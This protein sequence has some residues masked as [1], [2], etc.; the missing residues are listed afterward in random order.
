MRKRSDGEQGKV[1]TMVVVVLLLID[2]EFHLSVEFQWFLIA[3]SV[4]P[5]R[6][7][8]MVAHLLPYIAWAWTMRLSSSFDSWLHLRVGKISWT[9][10]KSLCLS[11]TSFERERERVCYWKERALNRVKERERLKKT[12]STLWLKKMRSSYKIIITYALY[13]RKQ[14]L[15]KANSFSLQK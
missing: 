2:E 9:D 13:T 3:L 10:R 15:I 12:E 4:W 5:L 6:S 7:L 11:P 14:G 8:A 1:G